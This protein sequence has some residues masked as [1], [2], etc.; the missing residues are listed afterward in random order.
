MGGEDGFFIVIHYPAISL[1]GKPIV[2]FFELDQNSTRR[3]RAAFAIGLLLLIEKWKADQLY[4]L[5]G[6]KAGALAGVL[7][8]VGFCVGAGSVGLGGELSGMTISEGTS[9]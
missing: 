4:A 5:G 3:L 9:S 1:L 8:G 2:P 7:S 6:S